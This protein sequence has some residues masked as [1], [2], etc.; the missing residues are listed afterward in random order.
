MSAFL[1]TAMR[2]IV[3]SKELAI[4]DSLGILALNTVWVKEHCRMV[5]TAGDPTGKETLCIDGIPFLEFGPIIQTQE[6]VGDS[7]RIKFSQSVKRL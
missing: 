3:S 1:E 7:Y 5:S 2:S 4:K 6:L